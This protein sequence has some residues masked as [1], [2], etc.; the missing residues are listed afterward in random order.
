MSI[1]VTDMGMEVGPMKNSSSSI[2]LG[3]G[4]FLGSKTAV[5]HY[6]LFPESFCHDHD[7]CHH[8]REQ[9]STIVDSMNSDQR[10]DLDC[11]ERLQR[12]FRKIDPLKQV[13]RGLFRIGF[14]ERFVDVGPTVAYCRLFPM[15]E[16]F[17]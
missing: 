11:L 17:D 16:I 2:F 4:D 12:G 9:Y 3:S 8:D 7:H 6:L 15:M 5:V 1:H 14:I 10:V 13:Q